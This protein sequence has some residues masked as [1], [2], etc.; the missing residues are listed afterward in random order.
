MQGQSWVVDSKQKAD[1]FCQYVR[2]QAAENTHRIY[3]IKYGSR[4]NKQSNALHLMFREVASAMND[5]GFHQAHPWKP[6]LEIPYNEES[7]KS[8][9]FQPIIK[10][11]Y[12]KERTSDLETKELSDASEH[13]LNALAKHTGIVLQFPHALRNI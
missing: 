3:Q 1:L 7:V 12:D 9:F 5:A 2:E 10:A 8:L 4:S 11:L 6:E 13:M